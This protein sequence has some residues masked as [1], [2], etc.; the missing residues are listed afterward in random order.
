MSGFKVQ[1]RT[2]PAV[3]IYSLIGT[4]NAVS[5]MAGSD[6]PITNPSIS[7]GEN[8]IA[9]ITAG[10]GTPFVVGANYRFHWTS[11]AEI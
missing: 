7:V 9:I 1:K 11:D 6:I 4:E 2:T 8:G 10:S 3:N 5:D